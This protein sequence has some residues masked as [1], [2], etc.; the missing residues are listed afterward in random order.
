MIKVFTGPMF[1]GKST[2]L[3]ETY[4]SIW[5]KSTCVCFKP[6]KDNRDYSKLYSRNI[7][8]RVDAIVIKDLSEI[9][10]HID[11]TTR[12]IFID[13]IQFLTGNVKVLVDLSI[14]KDIDVY[15][16]G[17]NMTSEQ[18]PFGLM[19]HVMAVADEIQL[20][21][22]TCYDC[23]RPAQYTYC[24]LPKQ[25]EVMVGNNEYIPLCK[26]C[27]HKRMEDSHGKEE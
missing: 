10:N 17:L 2:A 13:E 12:T 8:Q 1:S 27:L 9:T 20:C 5:N 6:S 23:N 3:I 14:N 7:K 21:K 19:P 16:A 4:T 15:V 24:L 18:V 25:D 26:S 11:C 22:A